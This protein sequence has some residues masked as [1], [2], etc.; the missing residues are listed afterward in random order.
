MRVLQILS[1]KWHIKVCKEVLHVGVFHRRCPWNSKHLHQ[2]FVD[3]KGPGGLSKKTWGSRT[4]SSD[5]VDLHVNLILQKRPVEFHEEGIGFLT[6]TT[7]FS[8]RAALGASATCI[9]GS[10]R[11]SAFFRIFHVWGA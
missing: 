4:F 6:L 3:K 7:E 2:I 5:F 10:L 9:V 11:L 1:D 8:A